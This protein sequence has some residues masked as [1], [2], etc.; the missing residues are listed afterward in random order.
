VRGAALGAGPVFRNG[1]GRSWIRLTVS[2]IS[3]L[4]CNFQ[5]NPRGSMGRACLSG[6]N[7]DH[8]GEPEQYHKRSRHSGYCGLHLVFAIFFTYPHQYN[9]QLTGE[10]YIILLIRQMCISGITC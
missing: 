2:I 6:L 9:Q 8:A 10:V 7:L 3:F 1:C 5:S 4:L